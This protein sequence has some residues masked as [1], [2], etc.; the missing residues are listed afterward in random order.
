MQITMNNKRIISIFDN[1]SAAVTSKCGA[2]SSNDRRPTALRV[3]ELI[4]PVKLGQGNVVREIG[5]GLLE[6]LAQA[7][8]EAASGKMSTS[9]WYGLAL[10]PN[11]DGE[12]G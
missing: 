7:Y 3:E 8:W 1:L 10:R 11:V 12:T 6:A 9:S 5:G 4:R 2:A